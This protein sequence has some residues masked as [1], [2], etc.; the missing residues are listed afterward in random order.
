MAEPTQLTQLFQNLIGNAI[1]FR[2]DGVT[3]EIH[4][5]VKKGSGFRGQG[6]GAEREVAR[7]SVAE[8]P[9]PNPEP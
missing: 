4:V 5:G 1:K 3:P 6:S 2:R 8:P 9:S 7:P